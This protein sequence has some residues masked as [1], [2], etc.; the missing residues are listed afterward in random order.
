M[1]V[2]TSMVAQAVAALEG[3]FP[4]AAAAERRPAGA[5]RILMASRAHSGLEGQL[6][7]R[8]AEATTEEGAATTA[9]VVR[10]TLLQAQ[11]PFIPTSKAI[12]IALATA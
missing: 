7:E 8:G 3:L 4:Q 5:L 2:T 12:V 11:R 10:A 1:V 9:E 6:V